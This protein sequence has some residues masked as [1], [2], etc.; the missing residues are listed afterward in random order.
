M[1]IVVRATR[2]PLTVASAVRRQIRSFDARLPV[3][4]IETMDQIVWNSVGRPRFNA[5]LLGLSG[6][7]ALLL[8]IIGV[9]G[10]MSYS[11]Q[12]RTHE[13]GIRRALGAETT[14]SDWCSAKRSGL[15]SRAL[16][17]APSGQSS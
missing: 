3:G 16:L 15:S 6:A 13:I 1:T 10:V 2:D 14:C 17:P 5:L 11:V 8:A 7:I 12:R 4:S 9:Y